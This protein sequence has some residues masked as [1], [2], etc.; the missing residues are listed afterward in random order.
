MFHNK[1]QIN[2]V[3][4]NIIKRTTALTPSLKLDKHWWTNKTVKEHD[5]WLYSIAQ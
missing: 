1:M 3:E 4:C 2:C 5:Y